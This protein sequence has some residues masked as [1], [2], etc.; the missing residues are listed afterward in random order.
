MARIRLQVLNSN[1]NHTVN[2]VQHGHGQPIL[3]KRHPDDSAR[4]VPK[5][6]QPIGGDPVWLWH[7]F[8]ILDEQIFLS[9]LHIMRS[10]V[11]E[12]DERCFRRNVEFLQFLE[13]KSGRVR[14]RELHSS[15]HGT[16]TTRGR[17]SYLGRV[18]KCLGSGLWV[19]IS[20]QCRCACAF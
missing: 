19:V 16:L 8:C 13:T 2:K 3:H 15:R 7:T 4:Q 20:Q 1:H 18:A 10:R 6:S 17:S 5:S 12:S 9:A 14:R 11:V